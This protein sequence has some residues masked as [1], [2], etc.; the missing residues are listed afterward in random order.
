MSA[1]RT[2]NIGVFVDNKEVKAECVQVFSYL[3]TFAS[4]EIEIGILDVL[5]NGLAPLAADFKPKKRI[6]TPIGKA[7]H[8]KHPSDLTPAN[9][10][11]ILPFIESLHLKHLD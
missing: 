8:F 10:H 5:K 9:A 3:H 7:K 4:L 11:L 2:S 1:G 6:T